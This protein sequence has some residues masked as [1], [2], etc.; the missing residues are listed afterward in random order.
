MALAVCI[1]AVP[2]AEEDSRRVAM[3][4]FDE[5]MLISDDYRR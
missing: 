1:R 3:R 4:A 2:N 5:S